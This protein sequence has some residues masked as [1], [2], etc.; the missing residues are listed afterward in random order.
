MMKRFF[1]LGDRQLVVRA[2][3]FNAFNQDSYGLPNSNMS[4]A[5]FG[6]NSNNWGRRIVTLSAKFIW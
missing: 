5:S 4:S 3:A 2:D 6:L 1:L